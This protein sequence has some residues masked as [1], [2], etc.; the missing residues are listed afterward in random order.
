MAIALRASESECVS[1]QHK[2]VFEREK[3]VKQH[4]RDEYRKINYRIISPTE[5]AAEREARED[6][7]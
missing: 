3:L 2:N 7:D 6:G 5:A 4:L 1:L